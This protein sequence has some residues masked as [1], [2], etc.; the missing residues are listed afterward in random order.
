MSLDEASSDI[1][2]VKWF[3]PFQ[4]EYIGKVVHIAG[5]L[6][7][8]E[9]LTEADYNIQVQAVKLRRRVA[10]YQWVEESFDR[11]GSHQPQDV[12]DHD[13]RQYYYTREWKE[14]L[15]DST[16]FNLRSGHQ[17]PPFFPIEAK[18]QIA[19][20]VRI[21]EYEINEEI[22]RS[23]TNY[24]LITSDTR[25]DIPGVKLHS[26]FYYHC[27]DVHEPEVGDVRLQFL[28]AGLEGT[29]YSLMGQLNE[30]G[31]IEPYKSKLGQSV[32]IL[33]SGELTVD[34][35]LSQ[36]HFTLNVKS[37]MMRILGTG[38]LFIALT[39]LSEL[40]T[41]YR[42]KSHLYSPRLISQSLISSLLPGF[43]NS[44]TNLD[45]LRSFRWRSV[46]FC[47]S[48]ATAV[49]LMSLVWSCHKPL[50]GLGLFMC[51]AIFY[52]YCLKMM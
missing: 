16:H 51:S 42:K 37:W 52:L 17:N 49:L 30:S 46:R 27:N 22:K 20:H 35:M 40:L 11:V 2:S 29:T 10:M 25:P 13:E 44:E 28:L 36:E 3:Q 48:L 8:G 38:L 18:T 47:F 33:K 41:K 34:E 50:T 6:N 12:M 31:V 4:K 24:I 39:K 26:G 23:F 32:L 14:Q 43:S 15:I 19:E 1:V 5:P 45:L 9:P 7:T 21:G